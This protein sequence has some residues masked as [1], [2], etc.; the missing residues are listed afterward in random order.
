M[1]K[2]NEYHRITSTSVSFFEE[3]EIFCVSLFFMSQWFTNEKDALEYANFLYERFFFY[4]LPNKVIIKKYTISPTT[5][6]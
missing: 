1:S 4:N 5:Y 3:T 2:K 6:I